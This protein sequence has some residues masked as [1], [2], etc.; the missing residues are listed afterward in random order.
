[1]IQTS[2]AEQ[3]IKSLRPQD[4]ERYRGYLGTILPRTHRDLFRRWVFAYASVHTSW[5]SNVRMYRKLESMEWLG[6][7]LRLKDLIMESGAG[8]QNQ[9]T[10]FLHTFSERFWTHPDWFW[11]SSVE[12][13]VQ[14]RDRLR[15]SAPGIGQAKAS[16][17]IEM[18]YPV[19]S[20][21]VCSDSHFFQAYGNTT[22]DITAGKISD[23]EEREMEAHWVKT[24]LEH[25]VPPVIAR[26]A[27][28]DLKQNSFGNPR[29]W[30][31]VFEERDLYREIKKGSQDG[32]VALP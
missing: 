31:W 9:R 28:W 14:Y 10:R 29:Y 19:E 26:W 1:M 27:A 18:T 32:P 11:K 30:T 24:C 16:F 22:K 5:R 4:V 3:H 21:V 12:T 13:W 20:E 17:V 6:D 15:D 7:P 25:K 8:F 23:K 2:E